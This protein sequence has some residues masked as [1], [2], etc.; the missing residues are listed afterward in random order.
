VPGVPP[1]LKLLLDSLVA[2][3]QQIQQRTDTIQTYVQA[4]LDKSRQVS[5]IDALKTVQ[6]VQQEQIQ[7]M[8]EEITELKKELHDMTDTILKS[9]QEGFRRTIAVQ[10]AILLTV[11]TALIGLAVKFFFHG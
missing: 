5:E 11:V 2:Q 4:E 8:K 6:S 7:R 9:Q 1:E 3:I 10:G